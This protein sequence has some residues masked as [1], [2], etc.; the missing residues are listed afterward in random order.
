MMALETTSRKDCLLVRGARRFVARRRA[1]YDWRT[2]HF[3]SLSFCIGLVQLRTA[4]CGIGHSFDSRTAG[5]EMSMYTLND[6][7]NLFNNENHGLH[8]AILICRASYT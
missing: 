4:V 6:L 1:S 8:R 7:R 2:S 3:C 5:V